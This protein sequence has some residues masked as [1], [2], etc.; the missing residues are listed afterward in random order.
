MLF[1]CHGLESCD[2]HAYIRQTP[3]VPPALGEMYDQCKP[4][5]TKPCI[6]M[7][8]AIVELPALEVLKRQMK[9]HAVDAPTRLKLSGMSTYLSSIPN[10]NIS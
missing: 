5:N 8:C 4:S 9:V 10:S 1:S 3:L 7:G 2:P 6:T